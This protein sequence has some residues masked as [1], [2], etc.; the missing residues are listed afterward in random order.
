MFLFPVVVL[1][2]FLLAFCVRQINQYQR[3]VRFTFGKYTSMAEP[4]WRLVLPVI[5]SMVKVDV[6]TKAVEVPY[7][8]A[9]TKDNVSCKINAV[10]YYRIVDAAR[11][12]IEV[13]NVWNAASQLAQTTMRNVVGEMTLDDLLSE[14]DQASG[15]IKELIATHTASWGIEVQGVELKDISLPEDMQRTIAK[16]AEAERE[17][18]A[19]IINSQGEIAAAENLRQAAEILAAS[20]GAL[21]LRTLNSINDISSDQ[22]NTVVF[23]VPLEVLKAFDAWSK[24]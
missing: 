7:Q 23:A 6:R 14:R 24:K 4:G 10:I 2:A 17:R 11:S 8:D 1:V 3:G 19:V 22:S 13:E 15:R 20:P 21:H 18:R 12:V 16:Q 9:I 5:Q